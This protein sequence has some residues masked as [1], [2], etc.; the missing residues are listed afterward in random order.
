MSE[1]EKITCIICPAG[2][3]IEVKKEDDEITNVSGYG[4]LKGKEY[5]TEE[6]KAPKRVVMSVVKCREGEM[7]TVSVKTNRPI[8]KKEIGN[9]MEEISE[10]EVKAPVKIGDV[11]IENVAGTKADVV[12]TRHS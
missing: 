5:A 12:A 6:A 9:V 4:C 1:T 3:E 8:P 7:P 10:V 2:C 11:I